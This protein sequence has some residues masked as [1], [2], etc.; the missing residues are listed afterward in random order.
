[1]FN[2]A[3]K[4]ND[5]FFIPKTRKEMDDPSQVGGADRKSQS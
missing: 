5:W 4:L 1:M 3:A 2:H